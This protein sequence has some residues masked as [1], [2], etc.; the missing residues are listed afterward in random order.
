MPALIFANGGMV[1]AFVM[2]VM[3]MARK[4][5]RHL[6]DLVAGTQVQAL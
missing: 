3:G 4:D 2:L 5:K 1:L 6:G